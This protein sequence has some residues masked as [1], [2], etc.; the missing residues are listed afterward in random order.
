M[1]TTQP[2][3]TSVPEE[4]SF[5]SVEL[6]GHIVP[7]VFAACAIVLGAMAPDARDA[8]TT[9]NVPAPKVEQIHT[10]R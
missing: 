2:I 1:E 9:K 5:D 4:S 6:L 7:L 8:D 10:K 3:P